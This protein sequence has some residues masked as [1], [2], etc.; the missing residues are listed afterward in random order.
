[1]GADDF[2]CCDTLNALAAEPRLAGHHALC[3][4]F[5][6]SAIEARAKRVEGWPLSGA[7]ADRVVLLRALRERDAEVQ[8]LQPIVERLAEGDSAFLPVG[9]R[10]DA[11]RA[12]GTSGATDG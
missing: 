8:R 12:L 10:C 9:L 6:R 2:R 7:E 5:G 1:M 11:R 4:A 3:A